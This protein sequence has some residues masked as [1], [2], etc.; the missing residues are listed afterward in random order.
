MRLAL[1]LLLPLA[2]PAQ[3]AQ[4][5]PMHAYRVDYTIRDGSDAAKAGRKYTLVGE[6]NDRT[7]M[8]T[9]DRVAVPQSNFQAGTGQTV[10]TQYT[11]VDVGVNIDCRVTPAEEGRVHLYSSIEVSNA[12]PSEKP[13]VP[14]TIANVRTSS[15]SMLPLG[16]PAR[17]AAIDDP[18]TG[19]RFDIEATVTQLN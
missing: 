6:T 8:R 9:G 19:R 15:T 1:A 10:S 13:G 7:T 17:V 4:K 2:L 12:V 11:Y 3:E 18:V 5:P 14:P 16:K